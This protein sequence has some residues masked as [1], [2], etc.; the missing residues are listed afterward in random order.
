MARQFC[1]EAFGRE[2]DTVRA[3]AREKAHLPIEYRILFHLMLGVEHDRSGF[4]I[5]DMQFEARAVRWALPACRTRYAVLRLTGAGVEMAVGRDACAEPRVAFEGNFGLESRQRT[6]RR[7]WRELHPGIAEA[8][9]LELIDDIGSVLR[10]ESDW[11]SRR[12]YNRHRR[13]GP[14]W[15]LARPD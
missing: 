10:A 2:R 14:G 8:I 9:E 13:P 6:A 1:A 4:G 12:L 11:R 7:V 5:R 15:R 3:P